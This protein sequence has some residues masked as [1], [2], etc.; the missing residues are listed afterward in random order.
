MDP[1]QVIVVRPPGHI[2]LDAAEILAGATAGYARGDT[3]CVTV[4]AHDQG[5]IDPSGR[6]VDRNTVGDPAG[7]EPCA[8]HV[9]GTGRH[10]GV[11]HLGVEVRTVHRAGLGTVGTHGEGGAVREDDLRPEKRGKDVR[12]HAG[13]FDDVVGY[14]ARTL[15]RDSGAGVLLEHDHVRVPCKQGRRAAS[16]WTAADDHDVTHLLSSSWTSRSPR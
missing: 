7:H 13:Q 8:E 2:R 3:G 10:G 12:P 5:R 6:G 16:G 15:H 1:E 14:Q 9:L 4:R 11:S